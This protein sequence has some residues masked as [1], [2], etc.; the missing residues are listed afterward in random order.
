MK[1]PRK[2]AAL[3]RAWA[4][5]A[6]IEWSDSYHDGSWY[7]ADPPKWHTSEE[8]RIKPEPKPNMVTWHSVNLIST[9]EGR[10]YR[11]DAVFELDTKALLRVEIDHNDMD[12]PVLVSATLE[13]P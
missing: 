9:G 8:Y 3:I 4:D 12:N 6:E 7:P 2:H 10:Y 5:G 1:T 11:S 13:K